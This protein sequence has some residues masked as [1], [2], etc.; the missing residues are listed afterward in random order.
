M[1]DEDFIPLSDL[2]EKEEDFIPLSDL[3]PEPDKKGLVETAKEVFNTVSKSIPLSDRV[4]SAAFI[5][6]GVEAIEKGI[7]LEDAPYVAA[8]TLSGT[9]PG[10]AGKFAAN[11]PIAAGIEQGAKLIDAV[12]DKSVY[13]KAATD[14][15]KSLGR[16]GSTATAFAT[17]MAGVKEPIGKTISKFAAEQMKSG[18]EKIANATSKIVDFDTKVRGELFQARVKAGNAFEESVKNV[19]KVNPDQVVNLRPALDGLGIEI[20]EGGKLVGNNPKILADIKSVFRKSGNKVLQKLVSDGKQIDPLTN[21][22][23]DLAANLSLRDSQEIIKS[24]KKIPSL[25]Q[26]LN[27]GKFAQYS[28]TDIPVLQFIEDVR[29]AQLSA[30]PEFESTLSAYRETMHKF[31]ALKPY[32]K[33][34]NLISNIKSNFQ[35]KPVIQRFVNDLLPKSTVKEIDSVRKVSDAIHAAKVI[36]KT[37]AVAAVGGVAAGTGL[38]VAKAFSD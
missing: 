21:E 23:I 5:G 34:S 29:D 33:E 31:R 3:P 38:A 36:G 27:Q 37:A 9:L 28:D 16:L 17:V 11:N 32:F 24:I 19:E 26:K 10:A 7:K 4:K 14:E 20:D 15:G 30:F 35:G 25:A 1:A 8:E 12:E 13:P 2:P 18:R 22:Q 6:R